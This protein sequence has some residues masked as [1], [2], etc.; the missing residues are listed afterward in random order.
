MYEGIKKETQKCSEW[1]EI[2]NS[3]VLFIDRLESLKTRNLEKIKA[4]VFR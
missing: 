3:E 4:E 2:P 1:T